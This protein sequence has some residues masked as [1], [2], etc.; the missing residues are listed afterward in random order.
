VLPKI[1]M[2]THAGVSVFEDLN[3]VPTRPI[4][5]DSSQFTVLLVFNEGLVKLD[6]VGSGGSNWFIYLRLISL[7]FRSFARIGNVLLALS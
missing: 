5:P 6:S 7:E 1:K 3:F 4:S 2:S